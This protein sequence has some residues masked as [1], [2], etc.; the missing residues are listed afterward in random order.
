MG[1]FRLAWPL[2]FAAVS[3]APKFDQSQGDPPAE[4]TPDDADADA[5]R[6]AANSAG[7]G[8]DGAST[9]TTLTVAGQDRI[10]V[11]ELPTDYDPN[12]AYPLVFAFH[13]LGGSGPLAKSYFGLT[14]ASNGE[15]IVAYPSALRLEDYG[16]RTGWD[17]SPYGYDFDFF[18]ALFAH[19]TDHLCVDTNRVFATGHSFGGYMSNALGCYRADELSAIAPVAGGDAFWYG[20]CSGELAASVIH[21]TYDST[22]EL[23]EGETARDRWRQNNGCSSETTETASGHCVDYQGCERDVQ[24]CEF[25]GGHEWP[26]FAADSLWN[27]F[28]AQ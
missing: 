11:L 24:W 10:Y 14:R 8:S 22:V 15:A 18:D 13:G 3:C 16:N 7:C 23:S 20:A 5:D 27:F 6:N 21:G 2:L 9:Q 1:W 28:S 4:T 25:S 26:S 12:Q 19:L 17:L